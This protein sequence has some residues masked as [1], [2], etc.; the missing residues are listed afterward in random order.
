MSN[1]LP[2]LA[3]LIDDQ[4]HAPQVLHALHPQLQDH[5]PTEAY[6]Y[7][8]V[9]GSSYLDRAAVEFAILPE[10]R[11]I[12]NIHPVSFAFSTSHICI[13]Q[14]PVREYSLITLLILFLQSTLFFINILSFYIIFVSSS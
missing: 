3:G 4:V 11:I 9:R 8:L 7:L 6:G 2:C 10:L 13:P 12:N 14:T 5:S 1:T